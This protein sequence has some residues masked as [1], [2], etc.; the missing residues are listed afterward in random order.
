MGNTKSIS[1]EES[2]LAAY[3]DEL[4]SAGIIWKVTYQP[5]PFVLFKGVSHEIYKQLKTK[6]TYRFKPII[7]KHVYT[8]DFEILWKSH[9]KFHKDI[10]HQSITELPPFFSDDNTSFV[11]CKA[12]WDYN[13]MT[14]MFLQRT[15]PWVYQKFDIYINLIKPIDLF[16]KTFIPSA[17]L[18]QFY[19]KIDTKKNKVGDKKFPFIY[20]TLEEYLNL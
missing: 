14:R 17:I 13:N 6:K 18:N 2:W 15:Q 7:Q 12:Q 11:E 4:I 10:K 3:F 20:K 8:P 5:E 19:Y 9:S 1:Q 16:K